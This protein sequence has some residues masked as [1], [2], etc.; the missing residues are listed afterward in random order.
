[1][2]ARHGMQGF[3]SKPVQSVELVRT[4]EKYLEAVPR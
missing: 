2:C 4:V 1:M 3:L